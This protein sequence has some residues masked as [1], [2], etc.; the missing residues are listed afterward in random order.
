LSTALSSRSTTAG[1]VRVRTRGLDTHVTHG[2]EVWNACRELRDSRSKAEACRAAT[3]LVKES[4]L[5]GSPN[6]AIRRLL[7]RTGTEI[8][9]EKYFLANFHGVRSYDNG[10][11]PRLRAR[12]GIWEERN[13][14]TKVKVKSKVKF[15]AKVIRNVHPHPCIE[16]HQPS[17]PSGRRGSVGMRGKKILRGARIF[18]FCLLL[19]LRRRRFR[20]GWEKS[21]LFIA[22]SNSS[23]I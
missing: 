20:Q 13:A 23:N 10:H 3:R 1:E 7:R 5:R 6:L 11:T 12:G 21:C 19:I 2:L 16:P 4:P 9:R 8:S 18:S 22:G 17:F 14:K 15:K